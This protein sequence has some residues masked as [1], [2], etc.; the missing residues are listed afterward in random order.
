MGVGRSGAKACGSGGAAEEIERNG[1][2]RRRAGAHLGQK[3]NA[4]GR[5]VIGFKLA[6]PVNKRLDQRRLARAAVAQKNHLV[7]GQWRGCRQRRRWRRRLRRRAR[8]RRR[9]RRPRR[10]RHVHAA[11]AAGCCKSLRRAGRA[12]HRCS[13][14]DAARGRRARGATAASRRNCSRKWSARCT[15][16]RRRWEMKGAAQQGRQKRAQRC[17]GEQA[18]GWKLLHTKFAQ[19]LRP[20]GGAIFARFSLQKFN[21]ACRMYAAH[22]RT[23]SPPGLARRHGERDCPYAEAVA[24]CA[25]VAAADGALRASALFLLRRR[26]ALSP[27]PPPPPPPP[28][29]RSM[30]F[31]CPPGRRRAAPRAEAGVE[32]GIEGGAGQAA[33]GACRGRGQLL[34]SPCAAGGHGGAR[35]GRGRDCVRHALRSAPAPAAPP[36]RSTPRRWWCTVLRRRLAAGARPGLA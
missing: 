31:H 7:L 22:R 27:A 23:T 11:G 12:A 17:R 36:C 16:T 28:C 8:A 30:P 34:V 9:H 35:L 20:G 6:G 26:A 15:A 4:N 10:Q 24:Q 1:R 5:A 21:R 25:A 32:E 14:E 19:T 13:R 29:A 33:Q 3:V 2:P 18:R